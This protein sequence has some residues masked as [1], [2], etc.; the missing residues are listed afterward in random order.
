MMRIFVAVP[1]YQY[2]EPEC[3]ES[4]FR[5]VSLYRDRYDFQVRFI[6]G[7]SID[8]ARNK[9]VAEFLAS[10]CE[11]LLFVDSD[12]IVNEMA[13]DL[14]AASKRQVVSGVYNKKSLAVREVELYSVEG[15]QW[16]KVTPDEVKEEEMPV[17]ACGFGM[18]MLCRDAVKKV[19]AQAK[20]FPFRF[21]HGVRSV[22]E[23]IFFCN[24]LS[25]AGI[26]V[27]AEGAA[28][29]GHVGKFIY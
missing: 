7:Y 23:D 1:V 3:V 2:P 15:N 8:Q 12:I 10:E 27:Y 19:V 13:F 29:V 6:H 28:K 25:K 9:A 16:H 22:S 5:L 21:V 24:E 17:A 11:K 20:G 18:V 14:L 4:L 26:S